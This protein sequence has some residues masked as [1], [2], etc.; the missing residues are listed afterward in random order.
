MLSTH[1]S[2]KRLITVYLDWN[3]TMETWPSAGY[4][5]GMVN[6]VFIR[7]NVEY[8]PE[9]CS[10]FALYNVFHFTN[11]KGTSSIR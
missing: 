5:V 11:I 10:L 4:I 2:F 1:M 9:L 7:D 3:R 8:I 6:I